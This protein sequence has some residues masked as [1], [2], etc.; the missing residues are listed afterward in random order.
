[1]SSHLRDHSGKTNARVL[2]GLISV[3]HPLPSFTMSF[4]AIFIFYIAAG[5][6]N[7][8]EGLFFGLVVLLTNFVIGATN[9]LLDQPW[10][11]TVKPNKPLVKGFVSQRMVLGILGAILLL[12]GLLYTSFSPEMVFLLVGGLFVGMTYNL[13]LKRSVWSWVPITVAFS[14]LLTASLRL[15]EQEWS[16]IINLLP[17][18]ILLTPPVHIANQMHLFEE[19]LG[20]GERNLLHVL[21][22]VRG[23]ILSSLLLVFSVLFLTYYKDVGMIPIGLL[24]TLIISFAVLGVLDQRRALLPIL[25]LYIAMLGWLLLG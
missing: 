20:S 1:M 9:D 18:V 11:R 23:L 21:G 4:L 13:G 2:V 12:L 25:V 3:F 14:L 17:F 7:N 5:V 8:L 6:D 15:A 24:T 22:R 10:D 16:E 19:S